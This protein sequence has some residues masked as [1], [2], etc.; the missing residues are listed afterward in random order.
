MR[1]SAVVFGVLLLVLLTGCDLISPPEPT[2]TPTFTPVPTATNTPV[3]V[4]PEYTRVGPPDWWQ[5]STYDFSIWLPPSWR[6]GD[7]D[8]DVDEMMDEIATVVPEMEELAQ[9]VREHPELFVFMGFDLGST[10]NFMT[11][12]NITRESIPGFLRVGDYLDIVFDQWPDII[13]ILSSDTYM[14]GDYEAGE[15]IIRWNVGGQEI[16]QILFLQKSGPM[17]YVMTLSTGE[18]EFEERIET[19]R[20]IFE[21]FELAPDS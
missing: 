20:Q 17:I 11:N 13:T 2:P 10:P 19:F 14:K 18:S 8:I 5:F 6:G 4:I 15:A 21:Y 9:Q 16:Q 12:I 3:P 7:A 1:K